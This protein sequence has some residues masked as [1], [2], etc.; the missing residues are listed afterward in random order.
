V[1]PISDFFPE[2]LQMSRAVDFE[3][4]PYLMRNRS[5]NPP[6]P[7][8]QVRK[9][10]RILVIDDHA[11]PAERTFTRDGYHFE[12][13]AHVKNLSQL[14][15]GHYQLILLD[16]QGVGLAES[17]DKQGLGILEHIKKT[18]PAQAVVVYSSEPYSVSSSRYIVLADAFL[19]KSSSYV[20]YKDEV[21][22]L[23]L[24]QATPGY[25]IARMNQQLGESATRV[26]KAVAYAKKAFHRGD[27]SVLA[28]YLKTN[29][30]ENA[31]VDTALQVITA[32]IA[33]IGLFAN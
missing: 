28:K 24:T 30:P 22:R 20:E 29:L 10:A 23:L 15:D 16:V 4:Y 26:P 27:P 12:R 32:G 11:F 9:Q 6:L 19:D 13:W 8:E 21:D 7:I 18:N 14:T 2:R 33:I 31:Q 3:Q 1:L 5:D 25:F 17:P